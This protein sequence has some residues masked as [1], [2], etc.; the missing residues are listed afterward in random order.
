MR[1]ELYYDPTYTS[2]IAGFYWG[3]VFELYSDRNVITIDTYNYGLYMLV[4][5]QLK[6]AHL[7]LGGT[8]AHEFQHLIH[9][10]WNPGNATFM[11]EG[12]SMFRRICLWVPVDYSRMNDFFKVPDNSLTIGE[13]SGQINNYHRL[14]T[15][16][17]L[18]GNLFE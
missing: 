18:M 15:R 2:Y 6:L 5:I 11:N 14:R 8:I 12:C 17:L 7:R 1:D 9:A 10:D 3:S 13:S 16:Y 4:I